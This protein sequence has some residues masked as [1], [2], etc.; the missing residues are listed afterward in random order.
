MHVLLQIGF[1]MKTSA[2]GKLRPVALDSRRSSSPLISTLINFCQICQLFVS[3]CPMIRVA[4][5]E[6][7]FIFKQ[8]LFQTRFYLAFPR[9]C[10]IKSNTASLQVWRQK[11]WDQDLHLSIRR[12][13]LNKP[14]IKAIFEILS[15]VWCNMSSCFVLG[16]DWNSSFKPSHS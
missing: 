7:S 10:N 2:F 8:S 4:V 9:K 12:P 14:G 15:L 1:H 5:R 13:G 16:H 11:I 3:S 6:L